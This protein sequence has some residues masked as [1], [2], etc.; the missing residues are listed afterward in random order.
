MPPVVARADRAW[1]QDR[2]M[3]HLTEL[4]L[5]EGPRL[6]EAL[7]AALLDLLLRELVQVINLERQ[8]PPHEVEESPCGRCSC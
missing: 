1:V 8:L 7:G 4:I 5:V 2:S 6:L 3:L